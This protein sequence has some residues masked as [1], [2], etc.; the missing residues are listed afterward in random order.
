MNALTILEAR[1]R[2]KDSTTENTEGHRKPVELGGPGL[3]APS[4]FSVFSVVQKTAP[5]ARGE[6]AT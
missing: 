4:V 3:L 1:Q 6:V 2:L 5:A